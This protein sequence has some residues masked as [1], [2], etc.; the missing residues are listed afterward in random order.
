M[1][2]YIFSMDR[3]KKICFHNW[4]M[5]DFALMEHQKPVL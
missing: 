3:E 1:S 4:L 2:N 5:N